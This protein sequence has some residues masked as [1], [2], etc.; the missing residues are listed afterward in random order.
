M[1]RARCRRRVT[2]WSLVLACALLFALAQHR[3]VG[4]FVAGP[5]DFGQTDLDAISD[6]E[7]APRYFVR[8]TGARAIDTGIQEITTRKRGGSRSVSARYYVL[9]LGDRLLVVKGSEGTPTTAEGELTAMPENLQRQ[10]FDTPQMQAIRARFYPYYLDGASFRLPGYI[11]LAAALILVVLVARYAWPAWRHLRDVSSHPLV[12]R[13]A[14]WGDPIGTAL[15]ARRE[16]GSPRHRGGGWLVTEKY[17][18]QSTVFTFDLLRLSDLLWAY[19]RVTK[20]RVNFIPT[21]KTY[22]AVLACYSGSAEVKGREQKVDSILAFA[23]ARAPW[24]VFGFSEER[25]K[26]FRD[27]TQEFC[28]AVEQRK[29]EGAR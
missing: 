17:L 8:V 5:Y 7:T 11:A 22:A 19:K 26:L 27:K 20:H 16:A 3:Y 15:E 25:H 14:S 4:N 12:K 28:S 18:I 9:V 24:A 13:V 29:R 6:V 23:A 2:A 21:G 1:I 10:L